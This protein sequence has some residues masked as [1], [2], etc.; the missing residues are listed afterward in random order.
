MRSFFK[1]VLVINIQSPMTKMMK[2]AILLISHGLSV[3]QFSEHM[4]TVKGKG[5]MSKRCSQNFISGNITI[6]YHIKKVHLQQIKQKAPDRTLIKPQLSKGV[7]LYFKM[8]F[9][10]FRPSVLEMS[11]VS[12]KCT[13]R[14]FI[15]SFFIW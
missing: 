13:C 2:S 1:L 6:K 14:Y 9:K 3:N 5:N 10:I 15:F 8:S 11:Q 4:D 12:S 7:A